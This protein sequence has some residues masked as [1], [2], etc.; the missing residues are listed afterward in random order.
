MRDFLSNRTAPAPRKRDFTRWGVPH[1]YPDLAG[2]AAGFDAQEQVFT[3]D[4]GALPFDGMFRPGRGGTL[5][6]YFTPAVAVG[7]ERKPP[8]FSWVSQARRNAGSA[9][10]LADPTLI[11]SEELTLGWYLG[12]SARPL[13]PVLEH[14]VG[15]VA[16]A[17]GAERIAFVGTSGGGFPALWL[18]G[19]FPGS[20]AFVNAPTTTV[21]DHHVRGAVRRFEGTVLGG[22]PIAEFP[23]VLALPEARAQAAGT[24]LII[25][26]N[27]DDTK[28]VTH[29][30]TPFLRRI[31]LDWTGADIVTDKVLLRVGDAAIWGAGH[32]M[33]PNP[34]TR[35]ILSTLDE[36][37][38]AGFAD[39]DLQALHARIRSADAAPAP[40]RR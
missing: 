9:L 34:V 18:S 8:F 25:T 10:F 17:S 40:E 21:V 24:R 7:S 13:Q 36:A 26:Q 4:L 31:G 32:V 39:L 35:A 20:V 15:T 37:G 23:G 2:F 6:V 38:G 33:P 14:V 1:D 3:I 30:L 12:T 19:R 28:F 16:R 29:H 5:F 27:G 22:A 11:L